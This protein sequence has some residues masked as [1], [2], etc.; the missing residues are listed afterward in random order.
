[1]LVKK[2]KSQIDSSANLTSFG[3]SLKF[4]LKEHV[5]SANIFEACF[6]KE[7]FKTISIKLIL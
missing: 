5:S 4:L 2:F 1:M 7:K 6:R 3:I